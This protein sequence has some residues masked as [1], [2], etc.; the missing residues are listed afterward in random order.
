MICVRHRPTATETPQA[1]TSDLLRIRY[2]GGLIDF[3]HRRHRV[4]RI[5]TT[6]T[7]NY[8]GLL[9]GHYCPAD[10]LPA[11]ADQVEP[12]GPDCP[13]CQLLDPAFH[14]ALKTG[15]TR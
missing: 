1:P 12:A 6:R 9:C 4:A 2:L 7:G 10:Q 14:Q 3:D 13:G 15:G 5:A 11:S 8:L